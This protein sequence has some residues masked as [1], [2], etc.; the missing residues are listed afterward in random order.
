[1]FTIELRHLNDCING[2]TKIKSDV[3]FELCCW[4]DVSSVTIRA[5]VQRG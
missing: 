1:M 3:M 5:K 4:C 2:I